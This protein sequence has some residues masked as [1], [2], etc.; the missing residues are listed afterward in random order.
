MDKCALCIH[1]WGNNE[2]RCNICNNYSNFIPVRC[3]QNCKYN[4]KKMSEYPC[5]IC[6]SRNSNFEWNE[7]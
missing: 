7:E 1:D 5:N 6:N 4:N 2:Y 3:C